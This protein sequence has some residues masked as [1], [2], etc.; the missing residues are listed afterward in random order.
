MFEQKRDPRHPCATCKYRPTKPGAP[1]GSFEDLRARGLKPVYNYRS[2]DFI[3]IVATPLK[4]SEPESK[5][6]PVVAKLEEIRCGLIDVETA[7]KKL[8]DRSYQLTIG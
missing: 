2:G 8:A 7:V 6:D 4:P 5:P 1:P 3:I